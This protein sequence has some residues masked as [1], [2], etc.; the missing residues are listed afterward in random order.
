M[1]SVPDGLAEL[2]QR[3]RATWMAGDFGQI[4]KLN[5]AEGEGFIR[6]LNLKPGTKV[7]DVAC[8]TGNQ[9]IPAARVG[10]EVIGLDLA[11]NLLEQARKRAAEENLKVE[12][13][14]GDAEKLPFEAAR[15]DVV[16][17]MFGAMFAPRPELVAA[18][19]LR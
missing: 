8:G 2:K 13:I 6:R 12:F 17:S 4:A 3:L 10:A 14:E 19:L 18:E 9:S 1:A 7:L 16:L 11:P 15:F 5:A